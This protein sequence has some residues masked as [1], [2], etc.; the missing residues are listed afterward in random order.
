[1]K[2]ASDIFFEP[3]NIDGMIV[4]A[5]VSASL[6]FAAWGAY[7]FVA[8]RAS[9]MLI[10]PAAVLFGFSLFLLAF[11]FYVKFHGIYTK[12]DRRY[13]MRTGLSIP[14]KYVKSKEMKNLSSRADPKYIGEGPWSW[15]YAVITTGVNPV[16][17][18]EMT[19][20]SDYVQINPKDYLKKDEKLDVYVDPRK[21]E[22]YFV[23]LTPFQD[24]VEKF[25]SKSDDE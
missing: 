18:R 11:G 10:I 16:T 4:F 2:K 1:M 22:R 3:S 6:F 13:L 9:R 8:S 12:P 7:F 20:E 14:T 19:F 5:M 21:P 25:M 23:D 17:G 24:R 15:P